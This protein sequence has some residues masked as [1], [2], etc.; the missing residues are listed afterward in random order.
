MDISNSVILSSLIILL[1]AN[2]SFTFYFNY[3]S[4]SIFDIA[5]L[6]I[7][8]FIFG[9]EYNILMDPEDGDDLNVKEINDNNKEEKTDINNNEEDK[10]EDVNSEEKG[11]NKGEIAPETKNENIN[12]EIDS[13]KKKE[14][15]EFNNNRVDALTARLESLLL[16]NDQNFSTEGMDEEEVLQ[17]EE[18]RMNDSLARAKKEALDVKDR[19]SDK[20]LNNSY[21]NKRTLEDS[22]VDFNSKKVKDDISNPKNN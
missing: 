20:E 2:F 19:Y 10:V 5:V 8:A 14:I 15:D 7:I 16:L 4:F 22:S 1:C 21:D 11:K 18:D 6:F 3:Y 17:Y 12:S 13:L 9:N